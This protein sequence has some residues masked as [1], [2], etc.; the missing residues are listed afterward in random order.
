MDL[1]KLKSKKGFT[2]IELM[3]V[4]V[5]IGI[6][7]AIALPNF[8]S[9]Q[10]RAKVS[11]VKANMHTAQTQ[12]ETYAVDWGGLYPT[13]ITA[14]KTEADAK[15]YWKDIKNPFGGT[16]AAL[17]TGARGDITTTAAGTTGTIAGTAPSATAGGVFPVSSTAGA[18]TTVFTPYDTATTANT[19][20]TAYNIYGCSKDGSSA[21]IGEKNVL[22][23]LTNG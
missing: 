8:I 2:L 22:F 16:V 15:K 13:G 10:D 17:T 4:I 7:V 19:S 12:L 23:T 3:V 5:I 21:Y 14:L 1:K 11:S 18:G 9:A 20:L 6:L